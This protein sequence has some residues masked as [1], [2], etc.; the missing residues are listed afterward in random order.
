[1]YYSAVTWVLHV[2]GCNDS[3]VNCVARYLYMY[4]LDKIRCSNLVDYYTFSGSGPVHLTGSVYQGKTGTI[5]V[6]LNHKFVS[7]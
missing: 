1:M 2:T 3:P 5:I 4:L 6:L 7:M